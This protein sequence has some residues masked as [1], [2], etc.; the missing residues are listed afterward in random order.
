V[1]EKAI[2]LRRPRGRWHPAWSVVLTVAAPIYMSGYVG[3]AEAARDVALEHAA[4]RAGEPYMPALA[5]ELE[6]LLAETRLAWRALVDNAAGYDFAPSLG[7]AND[8]L[9]YKTLCAKGAIR[10]VQKALEVAGGAAYFRRCP[11]ERLFRDVAAATYHPLPEA[12]QVQFT[13]RI[14]L[15]RDP[16][17]GEALAAQ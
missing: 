12:R 11:L 10:T 5:G 1:P 17:T 6:N 9:V 13:G 7:R 2:S 4:K 8:A 15:G 14:A 16:I 3:I